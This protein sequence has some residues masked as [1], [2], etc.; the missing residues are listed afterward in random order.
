MS[1][2]KNVE[3]SFTV[4][5]QAPKSVSFE[6]KFFGIFSWCVFVTAAFRAGMEHKVDDIEE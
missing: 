4:W 3:L 6:A 1:A 2:E 5:E